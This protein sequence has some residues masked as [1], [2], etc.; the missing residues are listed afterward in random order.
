MKKIF[1]LTVLVTVIAS[2]C[3]KEKPIPASFV[4]NWVGSTNLNSI[5][6]GIDIAIAEDGSITGYILPPAGT[7]G[8]V[9]P[10]SGKVKP[11][12]SITFSTYIS[13]NSTLYFNGSIKDS[14]GQGTYKHSNSAADLDPSPLWSIHKR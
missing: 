12:G 6:F 8:V 10:T 3:S 7:N 14:T 9:F 4:G 13:I 11:N 2:S 1:L 5:Y